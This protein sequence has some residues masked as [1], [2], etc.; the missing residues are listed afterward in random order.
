MSAL[1]RVARRI[2]MELRQTRS[3]PKWW[4]YRTG[5]NVSPADLRAYLLTQALRVQV[6]YGIGCRPGIVDPIKGEVLSW[7]A[8]RFMSEPDEWAYEDRPDAA[9]IA[10]AERI[11]GEGRE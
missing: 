6:A 11:E 4:D 9:I 5:G 2:G 10:L 8:E 3:G 1:E 7:S